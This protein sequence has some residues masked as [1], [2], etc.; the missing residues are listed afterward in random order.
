MTGVN[1]RRGL[2]CGA[3]PWPRNLR[4]ARDGGFVCLAE[5]DL[6]EENRRRRAGCRPDRRA[7][8][9]AS[10][11]R[12]GRPSRALPRA[13]VGRADCNGE[14]QRHGARGD[15]PGDVARSGGGQWTAWRSAAFRPVWSR[16][17]P[18][19]WCSPARIRRP[20]AALAAEVPGLACGWD[21]S[22]P[23]VAG[24]ARRR[25]QG[26]RAGG[27]DRGPSRAGNGGSR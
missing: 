15:G 12:G 5:A 22:A 18:T 25:A 1:L 20:V 7:S 11:A 16:R 23:A 17:S 4:L 3:L 24:M 14:R 9:A 13:P 26:P 2:A 6:A 19:G 10:A 8:L 21:P 27:Q